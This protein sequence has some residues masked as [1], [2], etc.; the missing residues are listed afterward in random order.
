MPILGIV[1]RVEIIDGVLT[2]IRSIGQYGAEVIEVTG[3][4]IQR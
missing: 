2:T 1:R 3:D 4:G